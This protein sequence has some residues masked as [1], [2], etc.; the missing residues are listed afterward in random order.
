MPDADSVASAS[1]GVLLRADNLTI[2]EKGALALRKGSAKIFSGMQ[3]LDVHTTKT[4]TLTGFNE[5][6]SAGTFRLMGVGNVLYKD[7]QTT[8]Q[9]FDGTG[10][11]AIGTDS[12]QAF[13]SRGTT[14]KKWDGQ[15]LNNWG[16]AAPTIAP[17]LS[18]SAATS[19]TICS[20]ASGES[21]APTTNEGTSSFVT[22]YD[23]VASNATQLVPS[24]AGRFSISKLFATDQD[25][26]NFKGTAGSDTDLFDM[27][28][29]MSEPT[30]VKAIT[31]MFGLNTTTDPYQQDYYAFEFDITKG[32]TNQVKDHTS[33]SSQAYSKYT[34]QLGAALTPSKTTNLRTPEEVANVIA[35]LG[36]LKVG[37]VSR[38]RR[39][40]LAASPAWA[41]LSVTRGQFHRVGGT[42]ARDWSTVRGFKVVYECVPGST[43]VVDLQSAIIY[44]GG[45]RA[46]TGRYRAGYRFVRDT[47]AYQELSPMSPLS[48]DITLTQQALNITVPNAAIGAADPQAN[49]IWIYLGPA[50]TGTGSFLDT[51]YRFAVSGINVSNSSLRIEEFRRSPVGSNF[52][53]SGTEPKQARTRLINQGLSIPGAVANSDLV[54]SILKSE[55]DVL[56]ENESAEPGATVPPINIVAIE[57][58][59]SSR[60]FA[61][62]TD[63][64]LYVS[65]QR[66]PSTFSTYWVLDLRQ[67]GTPLWMRRT[68]GGIYVGMTGDVI[69]I[70]GTG[71][72]SPNHIQ[73]DLVPVAQHNPHPPVDACAYTNENS[74]IYRSSDGLVSITGADVQAVSQGMTSLLWR[75]QDRHNVP[76]LNTVNG[77]FR[78]A[79]F[80]YTL[81]MLAPENPS[82]TSTNVIWRF[83]NNTWTRTYYPV[84]FRSIYR[85]PDGT[86]VAGDNIG[87]LW[88]LET[89]TQDDGAN[90]PIYIQT[91]IDD[92]GAPL[93]R[94]DPFDIQIHLNTGGLAAQVNVKLDGSDTVT[95]TYSASTI[96]PDV[97]R[98]N[99]S[100]LGVF[101]KAQLII[102]GSFNKF[103]LQ[104]YNITYRKRP[105][106]VMAV[107]TGSIISSAANTRWSWLRQVEID[108]YS[109]VNLT[110]TIYIDDKLVYGPVTVTVVANNRGLYRLSL[111]KNLGGARPRVL[112]KTTNV[113]GAGSVGFEPY[114]IR[115]KSWSTGNETDKQ[116]TPVW[117]AGDA[118]LA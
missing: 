110:M 31:V 99:A 43:D 35:R 24:A 21:P 6:S 66:R 54:V 55:V 23:G 26:L 36:A 47:G 7:G 109:P 118:G 29:W 14:N 61:L 37:A 49:Q 28:I 60:M 117:V 100:S 51:F 77:R 107:D 85:E 67:W 33:Y 73:I 65:G 106:Q 89:G 5:P 58:P 70:T 79:V 56:I 16:I 92:G 44:G 74:I 4:V 116:L 3:D 20:F 46:L 10:D 40:S 103:A 50:S 39:D 41:H 62:T 95:S 53:G 111:P 101:L 8:D 114:S 105:Q 88:Q 48:A 59:V 102:S 1:D 108:C 52:S 69:L 80:R 68:V 72:E 90:I 34:A 11:F 22:G 94:K 19:S 96:Q 91:P 81:F 9:T 30:K 32:I 113:D 76:A 64:F 27:F 38:E 82:T 84:Q 57:G 45:D 83:A 87:N 13:I 104:A 112:F 75:G 78:L 86:L 71:D 93:N 42:A 97:F 98:I 12:Y 25:F 18:A 115:V 63:G 15:T 2:D 17:T